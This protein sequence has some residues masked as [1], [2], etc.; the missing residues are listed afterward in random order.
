MGGS[1]EVPGGAGV[2]APVAAA[3]RG[4]AGP[5]PSLP[6]ADGA[7]ELPEG[8]AIG[9]TA[10]DPAVAGPVGAPG[11]A[12][13][14]PERTAAGVED[15]GAGR[16]AAAASRACDAARSVASADGADDIEA[17]AAG[18]ADPAGAAGGPGLSRVAGP[19]GAS[20]GGGGAEAAGW[21]GVAPV[22]GGTGPPGAAGAGLGTG[23]PSSRD[24]APR[25]P[26]RGADAAGAAAM[27]GRGGAGAAGAV[28]AGVGGSELMRTGRPLRDPLPPSMIRVCRGA[29]GLG[30]SIV[31]SIGTFETSRLCVFP[32]R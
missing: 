21:A 12:I 7:A 4:R 8:V 15:F 23:A 16:E 19:A 25:P 14:E 10:G 2:E 24:S 27:R 6:S 26:A 5:P 29:F 18:A 17:D 32:T 30:G 3:P 31:G 28:G 11:L 1:V 20:A 9:D 22:A 13:D